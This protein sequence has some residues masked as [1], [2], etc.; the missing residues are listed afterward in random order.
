MILLEIGKL[1]KEENNFAITS[2]T[3]PDGDSIG[4]LLGLYNALKEINKDADMFIDDSLPEK[5]S[6]MPKFNEIKQL[7]NAKKRYRCLF[8]LDCGD[9]NRLGSCKELI[10]RSDIVIN[11]D[12]HISNSLF[13]NLNIVDK[14]ASSVGEMI[15]QLIKINGLDV[16]KDTAMCL[17]TSIL[18]DT[19]GFKYSNTTSM[20][21]SIVGDLINNSF[22]FSEIY[23]RVFDVKTIEQVRLMAK[24]SSTL[25]TFLDN[26]I[27]VISLTQNM[28]KECNA[29]EEHASD[30]V[31]IVR[32][33]NEV[34]IGVFI[35]EVDNTTCRVS[36]RSKKYVDVRRIAEVFG[37]GGHIRAAGCT[38]KQTLEESKAIIIK[39]IQNILK[40]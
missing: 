14:N 39:E 26:K 2:H 27:G 17:Y 29:S 31:N 20:T 32:D 22:D 35:K 3:S 23:N 15:Y 28:L 18:T 5:Y 25:E 19:G 8:V 6:F 1:I 40:G 7:E 10:S 33:I 9:E 21:F 12:H 16:S 24:V 11:I 13:G 37:G 4:S 30:F 34:E 38:I 36:L